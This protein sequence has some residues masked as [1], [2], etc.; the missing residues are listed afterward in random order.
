MP[1]WCTEIKTST[2]DTLQK[3]SKIIHEMCLFSLHSTDTIIIIIIIII[4]TDRTNKFCITSKLPIKGPLIFN[5]HKSYL[6]KKNLNSELNITSRSS[7]NYHFTV[8]PMFSCHT[9]I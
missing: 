1:N 3:N 6:E 2:T 4:I 5:Y 9:R 8:D 7:D